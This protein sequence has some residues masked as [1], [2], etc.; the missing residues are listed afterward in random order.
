MKIIKSYTLVNSLLLFLAIM[1]F[2]RFFYLYHMHFYEQEQ[3]FLFTTDY[4][5]SVTEVPGGLADY[6]GRFLTQ[7]FGITWVGCIIWGLLFVGVYY[8]A[9]KALTKGR[10]EKVLPLFIVLMLLPMRY[11]WEF[12]CDENAM[13]AAWISLI[14]VLLPTIWLRNKESLIADCIKIILIPLLYMVAGPVAVLY[15]ALIV[16]SDIKRMHL[17]QV[18]VAIV[19]AVAIP[20]A[21]HRLFSWGMNNIL[22]GIHYFRFSDIMP[23]PLWVAVSLMVIVD[24]AVTIQVTFKPK[25]VG[26]KGIMDTSFMAAFVL[27]LTVYGIWKNYR[28]N[29]EAVMKYDEWAMNEQWD[30][31]L[32]SAKQRMPIY[33]GCVADINLALI[34]TEQSGEHLFDYYQPGVHALIPYNKINFPRPMSCSDIYFNIGWT[35]LALRTAFEAKE[36]L[37]DN[38]K[39]ARAYKRLA[40]ANIVRRQYDLARKYLH[41]L[42]HTLF[43]KVWADEHLRLLE[44]PEAL[45][46][47]PVYG[48]LQMGALK[49]DYFFS[50][51]EMKAMLMNYCST[52]AHNKTA[53]NYL[54]ALTLIDKDLDL[55]T[56]VFKL[57][58]FVNGNERIPTIYQQALA[59]QWT[60]EHQTLKGI[61]FK[62]DDKVK[63]ELDTFVST[64]ESANRQMLQK[65]FGRT[66][67][68]YYMFQETTNENK[69][70]NEATS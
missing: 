37:P 18:I 3:L 6:F 36:A 34:K 65:Q 2:Y 13:P 14:C 47:H 20:L 57:S 27:L 4:F 62:I 25:K 40:E 52:T 33:P 59:L 15:T 9:C 69:D 68:F 54:L 31:I 50:A 8:C 38:D 45:V 21:A 60:K 64:Y 16:I 23:I 7:F 5:Q 70:T 29:T 56:E 32:E 24:I 19:I 63:S 46:Q 51:D 42:Q 39:S 58:S 11:L 53:I 12:A 48:A 41:A 22:W 43:Y 44:N 67:W 30:K 10:E 26:Y 35:N 66:F 49:E 55:F 17:T 28:P 1:V 61:P